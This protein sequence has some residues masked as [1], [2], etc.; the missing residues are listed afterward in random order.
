[1]LTERLTRYP[2]I[3]RVP[4]HTMTSV[5]RGLDRIERKM[6][7]KFREVFQTITVDN[8]SEFQ[9]WAG[10]GSPGPRF[11]TATRILHMSGGAMRT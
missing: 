2:V 8:G 11:I 1:M 4:D 5:V 3:M 10:M 7:A 6:G 9:D